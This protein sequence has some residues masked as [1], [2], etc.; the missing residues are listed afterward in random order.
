M[1]WDRRISMVA[2]VVLVSRG[3]WGQVGS[4]DGVDWVSGR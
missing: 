3:S 4:L 1:R 2:G